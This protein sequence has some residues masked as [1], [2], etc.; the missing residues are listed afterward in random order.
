MGLKWTNEMDR[1]LKGGTKT[2]PVD[3][4]SRP[5]V[6]LAETCFSSGRGR[7]NP[8][9]TKRRAR[10]LELKPSSK[11]SDDRVPSSSSR[12]RR[13]EDSD[14]SC[15]EEDDTEQEQP[16]EAMEGLLRGPDPFELKCKQG[17]WMLMNRISR[18]SHK[19]EVD[20][21]HRMTKATLFATLLHVHLSACIHIN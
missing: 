13:R 2:I 6:H 9:Q 10:T 15:S 5:W 16:Q 11:Q 20:K 12:K 14:L 17:T 19:F 3:K 4:L 8:G 21:V 7:A 18:A 1:K